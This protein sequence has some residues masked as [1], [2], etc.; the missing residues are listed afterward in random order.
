MKKLMIL[1]VIALT[2]CASIQ[3][4]GTADYTIKPFKD[5]LGGIV[6]CEV[7]VKNGKEIANLEALISKQGENYTVYLKEQGV[8]AFKGQEITAGVV[9]EAVNA[10]VKA[11]IAPLTP[12]TAG[13][14]LQLLK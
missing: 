6:C 14:A 5:S 9:Q 7:Q 13:S 4:A 12:E 1:G 10:A 8:V 2:G 11:A 3:N